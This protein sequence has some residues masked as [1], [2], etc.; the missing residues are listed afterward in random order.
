MKGPAKS[1]FTSIDAYLA[2]QDEEARKRLNL[3]CEIIR[4]AAP[5]AEGRISYDMPAFFYKGRLLYFCAFRKHIGFYPASMAVFD[6]FREE[7]KGYKQSGRGTIQFPYRSDLPLGLIRK[8]VEF[9]IK[10][11]GA[12]ELPGD[13]ATK[14][15]SP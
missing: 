12:K 3:I 4:D 13:R 9:R 5:Q 1:G 7:L 8:I 2:S 10:E 15:R 11:N 14:P 6:K